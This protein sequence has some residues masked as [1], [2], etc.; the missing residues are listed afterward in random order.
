MRRFKKTG[1]KLFNV[2]QLTRVQLDI[3]VYQRSLVKLDIPVYQLT[4][5][6]YNIYLYEAF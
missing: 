4:L 2:Y 1:D 6:Q 3:P 5:I